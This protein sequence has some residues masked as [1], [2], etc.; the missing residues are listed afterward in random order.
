M[1]NIMEQPAWSDQEG[2]HIP[3]TSQKMQ[4]RIIQ[5]GITEYNR[6][7]QNITIIRDNIVVYLDMDGLG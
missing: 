4:N 2:P 7:V 3:I 6:T 1:E 5:K